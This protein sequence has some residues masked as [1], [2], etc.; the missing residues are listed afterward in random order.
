[1]VET[2]KKIVILHR[3]PQERIKETNASFPYL[4]DSRVTVKTFKVFDRLDEKKKLLKS[5]LWIFYAPLRV[6]GRGY[7]VIYCDDSFPFYPILVKIASPFSKVILRLG[8]L[9][10][11]YYCDGFVYWFFHQIEK[12][13]WMLADK[14]LAISKPMADYIGKKATVILDPVDPTDFTVEC[15]TPDITTIMFHGLLIENKN[16]DMLL[17]AARRLP[18][19]KFVIIGDGPAYNHLHTSAPWNVSM[20][21]WKPF[22]EIKYY[23]SRCDI[24]V[25]LRSKNKGNELVVTSP[26]L[27]YSVCS[28]PCVVS[29]RK[30]FDDMDYSLQ[31]ETA[32][33]LVGLINFLSI[34]EVA[35]E[36][37]RRNQEYVLKFHD[38]RIIAQQI[39][40]EW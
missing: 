35:R 34:K 18:Q 21:G 8:D 31:F 20:L 32:D 19:F 4:L 37:G 11:M 16:I 6:F 25:A 12:I 26:F 29:R 3:F 40:A 39:K 22:K 1:M 36:I 27:Q 23:I 30:V 7:D 14:I 15:H 33:E 28:K 24:G 5:I 2:K 10:L 13:G 17:I 9:H 38:A